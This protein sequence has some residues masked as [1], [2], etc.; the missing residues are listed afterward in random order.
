MKCF[1]YKHLYMGGG[2]GRTE[3]ENE[4]INLNK[5]VLGNI[6]HK[7]SCRGHSLYQLVIFEESNRRLFRSNK[8]KNIV[9]SNYCSFS[10]MTLSKN[11]VF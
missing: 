3:F 6:L 4:K 1:I 7:K 10:F 8:P 11:I 5:V 9:L 2:I